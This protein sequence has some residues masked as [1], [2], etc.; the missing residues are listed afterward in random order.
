M[1]SEIAKLTVNKGGRVLF[2]VHRKELVEQIT[3]SFKVHG[4][5]L[6]HCTIMTVIRVANRLDVLPKPSLIITDEAHHGLANTYKK[7]YSFYSDVPRL[8]FTATPWRL[9]GRGLHEVYDAMI[10]GKSVTWLIDHH[11]LAP[12]RYYAYNNGNQLKKLKTSSTGDYTGKS[13]DEFAKNIVRGDVV[14]TWKEKANNRKTIIYAHATWFSKKIADEFNKNGIPSAHID[15]KTPKQRRE[16]IIEDFRAG[17]IKVLCNVDLISEGVDVPDCSCVIMLRPTKS[18]VLFLQQAMRCMRYQEG[19][20][21]IILD[22]VS[23]CELHGLPDTPHKWSLEG[24]KKKADSDAPPIK[25]CKQCFAVIPGGLTECP[26]CGFKFPVESKETSRKI[27]VDKSAELVEITKDNAIFETNYLITKKPDQLEN[28]EQLK[29]YA[30]LRGYKHG[31]I[32]Y[33]MKKRGWLGRKESH[34]R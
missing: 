16:R 5:D 19:K 33:Q 21:A 15:A 4:V 32:Y 17:K 18:L 34:G 2:L 1:I 20:T 8:G 12:Y 29:K 14:K 28:I 25:E 11:R 13:M 10:V 22:Q 30:K 23:N 3:N 9:S 31:W 6:D 27:E 26:L 24:K 7:I